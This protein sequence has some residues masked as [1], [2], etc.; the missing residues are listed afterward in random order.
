[1]FQS[2]IAPKGNRYNFA[3][4]AKTKSRVPILDRPEGQSLRIC[5]SFRLNIDLFQSSIA[6]KGNRYQ[7]AQIIRSRKPGSNPRSPRRAIATT[8]KRVNSTSR[9]EFQSSIAPKGNRYTE[10]TIVILFSPKF[11]SSIAPKGNRYYTFNSA[12][13][14]QWFQSSIAPKGNRYGQVE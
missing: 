14:D 11:Q 4:N 7:S 8:N 5:F 10:D 1:M 6:P 12:T 9:I 3:Q 2:S 13:Y